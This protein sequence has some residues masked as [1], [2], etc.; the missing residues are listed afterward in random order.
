MGIQ[1][2]IVTG[3]PGAIKPCPAKSINVPAKKERCAIDNMSVNFIICKYYCT[4]PAFFQILLRQ[5]LNRAVMFG[6]T[7]VY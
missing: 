1:K 2:K 3:T 4:G 6:L 7:I 5:L